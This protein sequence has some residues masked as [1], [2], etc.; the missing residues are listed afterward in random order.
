MPRWEHLTIDL[1]NVPAKSSDIAL[2]DQLGQERWELVTIAPNRVAY[3]KRMVEKPAA[4]NK[5]APWRRQ[6]QQR[7][8]SRQPNLE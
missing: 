4:P 1:N 8:G 6:L 5:R 7:A 2:L 3:L